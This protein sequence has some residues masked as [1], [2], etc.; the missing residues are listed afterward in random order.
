MTDEVMEKLDKDTKVVIHTTL[1][2][3]V[4]REMKIKVKTAI[5][6][7]LVGVITTLCLL[8]DRANAAVTPEVLSLVKKYSTK[9]QVNPHLILAIIKVESNFNHLKIGELGEI[10]LMQLRPRFHAGDLFSIEHNIRSGTKYLKS[11]HRYCSIKYPSNWFV[12]YN[13]GPFRSSNLRSPSEFP[14][15]IKVKAAYKEM[16]ARY[17]L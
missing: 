13:I 15:V 16:R 2:V 8:I 14:Y 10:G 17:E 12:C 7:L 11:C 5:T 6:W 3:L 9:Y 4:K 1:E